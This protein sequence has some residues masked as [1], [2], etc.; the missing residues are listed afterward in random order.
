PTLFRSSLVPS[1]PFLDEFIEASSSCGNPVDEAIA[2]SKLAVV[3]LKVDDGKNALLYFDK[4][5]NLANALH[6]E[7]Y[8]VNWTF[9]KGEVHNTTLKQYDSKLYYIKLIAHF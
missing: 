2:Y 8:D 6:E 3:Y 5:I 9:N 1:Q 7:S 4:A